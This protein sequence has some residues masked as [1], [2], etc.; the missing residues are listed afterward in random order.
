[1]LAFFHMSNVVRYNPEFLA[2]L[3]DSR[4]WGLL[5]VLRN[6]AV[7]KFLKLFWENISQSCLCVHR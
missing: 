1:M 3:K 2:R 7:L 5:L 4:S 6:H